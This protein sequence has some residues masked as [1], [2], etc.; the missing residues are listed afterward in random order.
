MGVLPVGVVSSQ[1]GG[2]GPRILNNFFFSFISFPAAG[3][4]TPANDDI[5]AGTWSSDGSTGQECNVAIWLSQ[6]RK[7]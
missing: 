7:L 1:H 5:G 3:I 4:Y 6:S 2:R